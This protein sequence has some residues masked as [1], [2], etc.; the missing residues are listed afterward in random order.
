VITSL[1]LAKPD[2]ASVGD[3]VEVVGNTF[4]DQRNVTTTTDDRGLREAARSAAR[5]LGNG[6]RPGPRHRRR[7]PSR[8]RARRSPP[9]GDPMD[10]KPP[11][12]ITPRA[13]DWPQPMPYG[14]W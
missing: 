2:N 3:R 7:R 1:A 4:E 9:R 14:R 6:S 5:P 13:L 8:R 11:P 12:D 10:R